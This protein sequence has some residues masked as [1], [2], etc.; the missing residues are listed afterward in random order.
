MWQMRNSQ[1]KIKDRKELCHDTRDTDV[2]NNLQIKKK[3][4]NNLQTNR[5]P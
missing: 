4:N 1:E 5:K 3:T 2:Q